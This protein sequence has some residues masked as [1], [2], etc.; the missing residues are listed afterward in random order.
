[1][2]L[3]EVE[4]DYGVPVMKPCAQGST[5]TTKAIGETTESID[6]GGGVFVWQD[7]KFVKV[8]E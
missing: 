4:G 3:K 7:G 8:D 2:V 1:M 5:G 6:T